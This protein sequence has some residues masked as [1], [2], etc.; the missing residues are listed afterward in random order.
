MKHICDLCR[1]K[2]SALTM[3][4][5][6]ISHGE[7]C[8][9]TSGIATHFRRYHRKYPKLAWLCG[10]CY[11]KAQQ[12]PVQA[13]SADKPAHRRRHVSRKRNTSARKGGASL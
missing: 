6:S 13:R 8:F 9:W 4:Q 10:K 1:H 11:S 5:V 12:A 7:Y 3:S 2:Y